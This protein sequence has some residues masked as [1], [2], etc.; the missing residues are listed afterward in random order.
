[1]PSISFKLVVAYAT[2]ILV[3]ILEVIA[4]AATDG[5]IEGLDGTVGTIF[6][7]AIGLAVAWLVKERNPAPSAR[8]VIEA[9]LR[10]EGRLT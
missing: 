10:A 2:M 9:E 3:D 7:G 6:A 8:E 1:M 4:E 5:R